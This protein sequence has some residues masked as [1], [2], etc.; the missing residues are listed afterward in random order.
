MH[1][2]RDREGLCESR[3]HPGRPLPVPPTWEV[4]G[5][6][7]VELDHLLFSA[8]AS[9]FLSSGN[10]TVGN[11]DYGSHNS[12]VGSLG[13]WALLGATGILGALGNSVE[14]FLGK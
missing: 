11:I 13:G 7:A 10:V 12:L 6:R 8:T 1:V 3:G 2:R 5:V 4:G 14:N 9:A